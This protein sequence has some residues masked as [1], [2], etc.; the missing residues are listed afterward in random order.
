MHGK[1]GSILYISA[2][3]LISSEQKNYDTLSNTLSY[4]LH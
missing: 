2:V 1:L 3:I 4:R